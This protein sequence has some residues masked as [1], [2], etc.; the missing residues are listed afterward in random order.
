LRAVHPPRYTEAVV[1]L[2]LFTFGLGAILYVPFRS[3]VRAQ[4]LD[5]HRPWAT[6]LFEIKEHAA[7][8]ALALLPAYWAL[9]REGSDVTSR[10][11]VTTILAVL[12]WWNFVVGHV[13]NDVRGL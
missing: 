8:I 13:V 12:A 11:A 5:A 3:I 6:G 1:A 9:W 10:R 4:Y 7:A 2:F